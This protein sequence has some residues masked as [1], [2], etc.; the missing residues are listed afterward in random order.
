MQPVV[1]PDG[2]GARARQ[3]AV[4]AN[5]TDRDLEAGLDD[6]ADEE[7]RAERIARQEDI[8]EQ[9]LEASLKAAKEDRKRKALEALRAKRR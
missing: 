4:P 5:A 2:A 7:S 1:N 9:R 6:L 8:E 3:V